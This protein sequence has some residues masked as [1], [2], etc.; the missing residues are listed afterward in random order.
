MVQSSWVDINIDSIISFAW[1]QIKKRKQ[2][3]SLYVKTKKY[4]QLGEKYEQEFIRKNFECVQNQIVLTNTSARILKESVHSGRFT[5]LNQVF[6]GQ[7]AVQ[8]RQ[9]KYDFAE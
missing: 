3:F 5:I 7:A 1:N 6:T 9:H 2:E 4:T 8:K